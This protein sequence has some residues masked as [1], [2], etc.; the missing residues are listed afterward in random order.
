MKDRIAGP[1]MS[2][3]DPMIVRSLA[4]LEGMRKLI[5]DLLDLTHIESGQ[6]TRAFSDVDV[7]ALASEIVEDNRNDAAKRGIAIA[8]DGGGPIVM[9]ADRGEIEILIANLVTNAVKYNMDNGTIRLDVSD[10]GESVT[11]GCADTGIGMTDEEISRL[12][13]EFTRIKN[14]KTKNILGSGL[15]LSIVKKIVDL[16]GGTIDVKSTPEAGTTFTLRLPR[17]SSGNKV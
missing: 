14:E 6:K 11:I 12:F 8:F 16:Y 10:D 5:A 13:R 7:T 15:G 2:G 17:V 3:Y 4:R 9:H 1:D